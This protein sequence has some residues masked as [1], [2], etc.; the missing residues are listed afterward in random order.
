[1]TKLSKTNWPESTVAK[2]QPFSGK[3]FIGNVEVVFDPIERVYVP[4]EKKGV[5]KN[6]YT[7]YDLRE[8]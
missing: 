4:V 7:E 8:N 6:G 5:R 2:V 1:M 3:T